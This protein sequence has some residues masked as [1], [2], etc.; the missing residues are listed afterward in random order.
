M[1]NFISRSPFELDPRGTVII[2]YFNKIEKDEFFKHEKNLIHFLNS[3]GFLIDKFDYIIDKNKQEFVIS[4]QLRIE[5]E[6]KETKTVKQKTA[7]KYA[8][9]L[10]QISS[11]GIVP[12]SEL[13]PEITD[14]IIIEG[15]IFNCEIK[16]FK[17][18]SDNKTFNLF[19]FFITDGE[20]AFT[21]KSYDGIK[22]SN[23]SYG[24]YDKYLPYEYLETFNIDK[25]TQEGP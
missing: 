13:R 10:N 1:D 20:K 25:N 15:E 3:V 24:K 14:K 5:K 17:R 19:T 21:I 7:N 8:E 4:E 23:F 6:Q 11:R 12:I 22:K 16:N 9:S 18:A 2:N